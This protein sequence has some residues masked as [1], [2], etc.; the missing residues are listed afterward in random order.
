MSLARSGEQAGRDAEWQTGLDAL[1]RAG[2]GHGG[3]LVPAGEP[4]IG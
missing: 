4:G 3:L 1:D 2:K